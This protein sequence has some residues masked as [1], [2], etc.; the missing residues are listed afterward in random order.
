MFCNN[1]E[2]EI[3]YVSEQVKNLENKI[4]NFLDNSDIPEEVRSDVFMAATKE[5][6]YHGK[7]YKRSIQNKKGLMQ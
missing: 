2:D 6:I 5:G 4:D 7:H 3:Y 1:I